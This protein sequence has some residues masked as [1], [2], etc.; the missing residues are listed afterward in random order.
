MAKRMLE[1]LE[2]SVDE[3]DLP[4]KIKA[5][6]LSNV[7]RSKFFLG[8]YG[9]AAKLFSKAYRIYLSYGKWEVPLAHL[10]NSAASLR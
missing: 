9:D 5:D 7:A 1:K 6:M 10:F 3:T 4:Q 2:S 8:N